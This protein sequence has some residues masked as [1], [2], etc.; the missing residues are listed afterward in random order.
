M[1]H[2]Q[3]AHKDKTICGE[4]TNT[5]TSEI[6]NSGTTVMSVLPIGTFYVVREIRQSL[7]LMQ[8]TK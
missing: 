7:F 5:A 1:P 8:A 3:P 4:F 2:I 6:M